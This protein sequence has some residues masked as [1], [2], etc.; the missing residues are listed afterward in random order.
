[1]ISVRRMIVKRESNSVYDAA[2][3]P[4]LNI[5]RG[6]NSSGKST[7]LDFM[8]YGL[9]GEVSDWRDAALACS[10]VILEVE[11]NGMPAVLSREVSESVG[12]PMRIFLGTLDEIST[13]P[14]EWGYIH[15][16][17]PITKSHFRRCFFA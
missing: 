13:R 10:E 17:V 6:E 9:G 14:T 4:R 7:I 5:I 1:M 2:F 16:N 12:R 11:L 15:T 3:H 8:F